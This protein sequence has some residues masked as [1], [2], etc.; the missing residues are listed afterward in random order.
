MA[1]VF[2]YMKKLHWYEQGAFCEGSGLFNVAA[3]PQIMCTDEFGYV[4]IMNKMYVVIEE[5]RKVQCCIDIFRQTGE[6]FNSL[7]KRRDSSR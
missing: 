6:A 5:G 7:I 1:W 3:L 4:L 2:T